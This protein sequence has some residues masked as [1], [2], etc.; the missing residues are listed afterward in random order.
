MRTPGTYL[1]VLLALTTIGGAALAWHQY[2]ELSELRASAINNDERATWQKRVWDLEKSNRELADQLAALRAENGGVDDMLAAAAESRPARGRGPDN[3]A[4]GSRG[5]GRGPFG[6]QQAAIGAL[7]ARPEVQAMIEQQRK[8]AIADRYGALIKSLNLSPEQ[9]DKLQTL[10]AERQTSQQDVL[11]AAREQGIDPRTDREG[12]QKLLD[13]ARNDVNNSIKSLLGDAGFA[14]LQNFEQTGPQ[15]AVV[16]Q[17]NRRLSVSGDQLTSA[18]QEQ[19]VGIL[20]ANAPARAQNQNG[21]GGDLGGRGFGGFNGGGNPAALA[22]LYFGGGGGLMDAGR[23]ATV[24]TAAVNQAQGVLSATQLAALQQVQQQQQQAQQLRQLFNDTMN[25][26]P[27][28]KGGAATGPGDP[29]G[30]RRRGGNG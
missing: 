22:G 27:P 24:T 16:D 1:L 7:L 4:R 17:I 6:A 2:Q 8:L 29:G 23:G 28:S 3:N 9:A 15:R 21:P 18:Q 20:A 12:F 14:Q 10:L 5:G 25:A 13:D 19:L 30:G 11:A 26:N